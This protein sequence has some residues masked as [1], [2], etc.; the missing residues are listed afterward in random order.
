MPGQVM[1]LFAVTATYDLWTAYADAASALQSNQ[2]VRKLQT[3]DRHASAPRDTVGSGPF[4][5]HISS[6]GDLRDERVQSD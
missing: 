6:L 5:T 2:V 4:S 1:L 3:Q